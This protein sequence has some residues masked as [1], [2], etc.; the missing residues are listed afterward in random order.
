MELFN[1]YGCLKIAQQTFLYDIPESSLLA[2]F[3]F[4]SLAGLQTWKILGCRAAS[5]VK[6]HAGEIFF[7]PLP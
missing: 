2:D 3:V 5:T 7:V 6:F 4:C 1:F